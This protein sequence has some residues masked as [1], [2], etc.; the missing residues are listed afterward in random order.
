MAIKPRNKLKSVRKG[1]GVLLK[2]GEIAELT[3]TTARTLRYYEEL[4][5]IQPSSRSDG[6]FRLYSSEVV[7]SIRMIRELMEAGFTLKEISKV[8]KF[9]VAAKS[10]W[11][12]YSLLSIYLAGRREEIQAKIRGLKE[13]E[14]KLSAFLAHIEACKVCPDRPAEDVC[15]ACEHV[16]EKPFDPLL[17]YAW[18][19]NHI[20]SHELGLSKEELS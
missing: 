13:V 7:E 8:M 9:W 18:Q 6:K 15:T 5:L 10:G 16:S 20:D 4:G 11:E 2:I 1:E 3:K 12:R 17:F 19:L 14:R